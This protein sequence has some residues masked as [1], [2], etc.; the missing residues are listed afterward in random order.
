[1]LKTLSWGVKDV[2]KTFWKTPRL[3]SPCISRPWLSIYSVCMG[4]RMDWAWC[5]RSGV[6]RVWPLGSRTNRRLFP[7]RWKDCALMSHCQGSRLGW[8]QTDPP[9][10]LLKSA[11]IALVMSVAD[12]TRTPMS[13]HDF[14]WGSAYFIL[15]RILRSAPWLRPRIG[16]RLVQYI[17]M[18]ESLRDFAFKNLTIKTTLVLVNFLVSTPM[19][20]ISPITSGL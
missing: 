6:A 4:L 2:H 9:F 5:L 18:V 8:R 11:N 7:F 16:S 3:Q 12:M 19:T 20:R 17:C 10:M 14:A 15:V 1:V 13:F